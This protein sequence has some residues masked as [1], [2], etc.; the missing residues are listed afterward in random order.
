ME[1]E[2]VIH[3]DGKK[4]EFKMPAKNPFKWRDLWLAG[5]TGWSLGESW[6]RSYVVGTKPLHTDTF[7]WGENVGWGGKGLLQKP[8]AHL[9]PSGTGLEAGG[10][11]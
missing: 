4:N 3:W 2:G 11:G 7:A 5:H 1:T 9:K 10:R 8:R 6:H